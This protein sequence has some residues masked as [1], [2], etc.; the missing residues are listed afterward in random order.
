MKGQT[1]HFIP[2]GKFLSTWSTCLTVTKSGMI[3]QDQIVTPRGACV[4]FFVFKSVSTTVR[5]YVGRRASGGWSC[6]ITRNTTVLAD[7]APSSCRSGTPFKP[8]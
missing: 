1:C 7:T 4:T 6:I 3:G 8:Q 2:A 5:T